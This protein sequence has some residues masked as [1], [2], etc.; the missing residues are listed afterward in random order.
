MN[1]ISLKTENDFEV[2]Q[3]E[4]CISC[5]VQTD[6]PRKLDINFRNYYIEG[7][8]QLCKKCFESID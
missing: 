6:V 5:D 8:G 1:D 7:A 4:K 3:Y 2:V